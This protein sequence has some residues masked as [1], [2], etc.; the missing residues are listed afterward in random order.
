MFEYMGKKL[1][2][3]N[4]ALSC[5][6]VFVIKGQTNLHWEKSKTTGCATYGSRLQSA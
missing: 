2:C 4:Q 1:E 3:I 6:C 5:I